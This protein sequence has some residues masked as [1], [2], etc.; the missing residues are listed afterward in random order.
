MKDTGQKV[1]LLFEGRDAAGKGGTIKRFTEHLNPRGRPDGGAG[2]AHRPRADPVVLPALPRPPARGRGDRPV[3]PQLVQPRRRR[4]GH[5]LHRAPRLHGVP[6]RGPRAGADARPQRDP[7]GEVLVLGVAVRA[8]HPVPHP[9]GRPRPA[10]EALPQRPRVDPPLGRLHGGQGG[11]VLLHRHRGRPVD[12]GEEQRQE[13][14][15]ARGDAP[16][17]RPLR[18]PGEGPRRSPTRPTR[19]SSGRPRSSSSTGSRRRRRCASA[20]VRAFPCLGTE[21]HAHEERQLKACAASASCR[22]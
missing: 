17:P 22:R 7:A 19:R 15:P 11:D 3:R 2:E 1:V 18:L 6:A 9:P 21:T 10:L 20:A 12:G 5:G 16:R 4:A 8:A 14:R 13:A